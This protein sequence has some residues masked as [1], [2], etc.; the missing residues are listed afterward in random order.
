MYLAE[1]KIKVLQIIPSSQR[2]GVPTVLLNL[3]SHVNKERFEMHLVVPDDGPLY[4]DFSRVCHVY[5]MPIRGCYPTTIGKLRKLMRT[6]RI[7][8]VHAHGK[9]AGLYGRVASIG[10]KAKTV[11]TLHGFNYSHFSRPFAFGYLMAERLLSC[12]TDRMVMVS[13]GERNKAEHVGILPPQKTVTIP[14]GVVLGS[15]CRHP[16]EGHI[17]G[18]L[19]RTCQAKGIEFLIKAIAILKPLYPDIVC[20]IAGGTP[21]GEEELE[22]EL[23][24][25]VCTLNLED[26]VNFFGEITNIDSFLS[27]ITIYVSTSLWEGL[28]TAILEAFAYGVPVVATDVAGNSDLVRNQQTGILVRSADSKAIAEGIEY[29]FDNIDKMAGF[30]EN[31]YRLVSEEYSVDMMVKRHEELYENLLKQ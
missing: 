7:D 24:K 11:Y 14:N 17:I 1:N 26:H 20:S 18:T 4:R 19:S 28:P 25:M 30:S 15:R 6:N 27:G 12:I 16:N 2:G 3:L 9:G 29:A 5:H 8:I 13:E 31:A 10:L 21:E 22:K 23:H